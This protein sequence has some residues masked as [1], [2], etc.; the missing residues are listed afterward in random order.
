LVLAG[1]G[2]E[3]ARA[4]AESLLA[5]IDHEPWDDLRPGLRVTLS[6]GIAAGDVNDIQGVSAR[7]DAALYQAKD[8]GGHGIIC[9][10]G[11]G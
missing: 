11:R 9:S 6:I 2:I 10:R 5:Q 3:V 7:A 8:A 4:R 1:V